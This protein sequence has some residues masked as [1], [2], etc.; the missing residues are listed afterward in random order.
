[1]IA[2]SQNIVFGLFF[3]AFLFAQSQDVT[4]PDGQKSF[5]FSVQDSVLSYIQKADSLGKIKEFEAAATFYKRAFESAGSL[6]E[7]SLII[8]IGNTYKMHLFAKLSNLEETK[9]VNDILYEFCKKT[10]NKTC[11]IN[12]FGTASAINNRKGDPHKALLDLNKGVA[13]CDSTTPPDLAKQIYETRGFLLNSLNQKTEARHDYKKALS[14]INVKK[15]P[16]GQSRLYSNIA[17][18]FAGKEIDSMA[19]YAQLA[20]GYCQKNK[21]DKFCIVVYNNL[22]YQFILQNHPDKAKEL[23]EKNIDKSDLNN[24][25]QKGN[26]T[27]TA[28][29]H[30]I[31][32][33]YLALEEYD[34]AI[35][36]LEIAKEQ[37]IAN[38]DLRAALIVI[39]DL[40]K[41][42]E[43]SGNPQAGLETLRLVKPLMDTLDIQRIQK[44]VAKLES[45][46][47][48]K[49]KEKEVLALQEEK[50]TITL[51][52]SKAHFISYMLGGLLLM[53]VLIF[54]YKNIANKAKFH[55]L[56]ERM[57]YN[58]LLSLQS[59]MNPHFLFNSFGT[60]QHYILKKDVGQATT[61]M[62]T[63]S[64]LIRDVFSHSNSIYIHFNEELHILKSY[65]SL[66]ADRFDV[67]F[68]LLID[69]DS[70]LTSTNPLIPSMIIQPYVENAIIHGFSHKIGNEKLTI[71]FKQNTTDTLICTITDNGI[72]RKKAAENQKATKTKE[73]LSVATK[74]TNERLK[75]I[76]KEHHKQGNI[77]LKDLYDTTGAP[78][79]TQVVITLPIITSKKPL[80]TL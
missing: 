46:R 42:Y 7:D 62:T 37:S 55:R 71:S 40:T 5:S 77:V 56:Q 27:Y 22:A 49:E 47:K 18:T 28:F 44:E 53:G 45:Q 14:L 80:Y 32:A 57:N 3:F 12:T 70:Q 17:S 74:N 1:M 4:P 25:A 64:N 33:M 68:E 16:R 38:K 79:G 59:A 50:E 30:T 2:S 36:K 78:T 60:L 10:N 35:P 58:R 43:K 20:I 29:I 39:E 26:R 75:I 66:E 24:L 31:G 72:G 8:A 9:K 41:A 15:N 67:P 54:I 23:I 11:L 73:H 6:K 63:L 61:Y 51:K 76:N 65:I 48:L 19:Y 69:V 13:L 34:K 21:L 52:V